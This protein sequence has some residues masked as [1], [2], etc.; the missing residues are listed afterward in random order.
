MT[1]APE[2]ISDPS[3]DVMVMSAV[4]VAIM[5]L[6]GRIPSRDNSPA[7]NITLT[8]VNNT[9]GQ[10]VEGYIFTFNI[11]VN[12]QGCV[13][14]TQAS[15]DAEVILYLNSTLHWQYIDNQVGGEDGGLSAITGFGLL[16]STHK[17]E[18]CKYGR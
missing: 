2:T 12:L 7:T 13:W 16:L 4:D 17:L 11:V 6:N 5:Q 3:Q 1:C 9:T 8:S 18:C 10:V 15:V 14:P